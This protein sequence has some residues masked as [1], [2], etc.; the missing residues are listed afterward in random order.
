MINGGNYSTAKIIHAD[1]PVAGGSFLNVIDS[2]MVSNV[3]YN[4]TSMKKKTR[5]TGV[6]GTFCWKDSYGRGV[7]LIPQGCDSGKYLEAGLCYDHC[8]V[9]YMTFL[10]FLTCMRLT[11]D[12]MPPTCNT[13][14]SV[15]LV[16]T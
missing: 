12:M 8:P 2:V 14:M 3:T 1:I 6:E 16:M 13:Y 15:T 4:V 9:L 7:G 11:Y 10:T 5:G